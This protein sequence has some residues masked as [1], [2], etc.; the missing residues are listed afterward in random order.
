[1]RASYI[2]K[3]LA[4]LASLTILMSC[5]VWSGIGAA[6]QT[7]TCNFEGYT[8]VSNSD[9]DQTGGSKGQVVASGDAAHG[10]VMKLYYET[11]ATSGKAGF[12]FF[13]GTGT[14]FQYNQGTTPTYTKVTFDYQVQKLVGAAQLNVMCGSINWNG[15]AFNSN[16]ALGCD[17]HK[18]AVTLDPT[19][20]P[21]AWKTAS[22]VVQSHSGQNA[23]V[24]IY[25]QTLGNVANEAG[26]A[27]Y[28]DNVTV[29]TEYDPSQEPD[30]SVTSFPIDD[31]SKSNLIGNGSGKVVA[32]GAEY[33]HSGSATG[34]GMKMKMNQPYNA[35][36]C[37]NAARFWLENTDGYMMGTVGAKYEVTAW[38]KSMINTTDT[39]YWAIGSADRAANLDATV[40]NYQE[41]T[42]ASSAVSLTPGVW[43]KV[44]ATINS[45]VGAG[46]TEHYMTFA[47]GFNSGVNTYDNQYVYVD[48]IT[49][50]VLYKPTEVPPATAVVPEGTLVGV[51]TF[52]SG[53]ITDFT[54][55]KNV[56]RDPKIGSLYNY[57]QGGSKSLDVFLGVNTANNGNVSRPRFTVK[58]G[59][60]ANASNY[61]VTVGES[62]NLS[63]WVRST[64][65][66][67]KFGFYV[68]TMTAPET[69]LALGSSAQGNPYRTIQTATCNVGTA[70]G[71]QGGTEFQSIT[72]AANQWT[73]IIVNIPAVKAHGSDA[74]ATQYL[75]IHYTDTD[76]YNPNPSYT[77]CTLSLDEVSLYHVKEQWKVKFEVGDG[78]PVEDVIGDKNG[79]VVLPQPYRLGY[80]FTGWYK[81]VACTQPVTSPY[82]MTAKETTLYT[83]WTKSAPE[84]VDLTQ[85]FE[86]VADIADLTTNTTKPYVLADEGGNQSLKV[87][88]IAGYNGNF[89]R[90]LWAFQMKGQDTPMQVTPGVR[91]TVTFKVKPTRNITTGTFHISTVNDLSALTKNPGSSSVA[92]ADRTMQTLQKV[93]V[94]GIDHTKLNGTRQEAN[95]ISLKGGEWNTITVE[96]AAI[97]AHKNGAQY[98]VLALSDTNAFVDNGGAA[99]G[100]TEYDM[101]VDDVTLSTLV[102][103]HTTNVI[104]NTMGGDAMANGTG[105]IW[106]AITATATR[107]G[108][109]FDGWYTDATCSVP[110][111]EFPAKETV[112]LYAGW[113][114]EGAAVMDM[115]KAAAGQNGTVYAD[116]DLND[117]GVNAY[118]AGVTNMYKGGEANHAI[119]DDPDT[120]SG[121]GKVFSASYAAASDA[122][123]TPFGIRLVGTDTASKGFTVTKGQSYAVT[124]KYKV[125]AMPVPTEIRV[126]EGSINW[127]GPAFNSRIDHPGFTVTEADITKGWQEG[128][129]VFES[130]QGGQFGG[131]HLVLHA[132][133]YTKRNGTTVYFDDVK[134]ISYSFDDYK[135]GNHAANVKGEQNHTAG[136]SYAIKYDVGAVDRTQGDFG[137]V[138]YASKAGNKFFTTDSLHTF[139]GWVYSDKDTSVALG[140]ANMQDVT[141]GF[142]RVIAMSDV[143]NVKAGQWTRVQ[144]DFT[145]PSFT[146]EKNAYM[147]VLADATDTTATLYVDDVAIGT[148]VSDPTIM[149]TYE[150]LEAKTHPNASYFDGNLHG[151]NGNTV[152]S[153]KGYDGS[154]QSLKIEMAS[155]TELDASRAVLFFDRKDA[156]GKVSGSYIVTFYAMMEEDAEVTF[157]LGTSGT[158]DLSDRAEQATLYEAEA[159]S[160]VQL[161]AGKWRGVSVYVSDLQGKNPEMCL[162]PYLTLGAWFDGAASDNRKTVYIDNVSLREYIASEAAREDILCF[163][164]TDA[165]GFGKQLNLSA[166][167]SM[168]VVLE[169]NNTAGGNYALK[170]TTDSLG[171]IS[172]AGRP[173]FNLM[174]ANGQAIRV[175]KGKNYR[176]TFYVNIAES[177][178]KDELRYW[179]NLTD[180]QDSYTDATNQLRKDEQLVEVSSWKGT[181][182]AWKQI[183]VELTDLPRDGYLRLGISGTGNG[184]KTVFYL[185]DLRVFEFKEFT[186]TG[187]EKVLDFEKYNLE[188]SDFIRYSE[189]TVADDVNHT[190]GGANALRLKG[191]SNAGFQRNQFMLINPATKQP[192]EFVKGETYTLK[193]WLYCGEEYTDKFDLN[194]WVWGTDN[195]NEKFTASNHKND[196]NGTF[197]FDGGVLVRNEDQIWAPGEWNCYE[198]TFTAT[199]GKYMLVGMTDGSRY[200]GNYYYYVDDMQISVPERATV[201]FDANGGSFQDIKPELLNEKGQYVEAGFVGVLAVGPDI[202]PYLENKM[203]KG[204]ALDKEGTQMFDIDVD[205]VPAANVTLYAIWGEWTN[206]DGFGQ[207]VITKPGDSDVKY[208]TE[209]K[210]E[211]VWTGNAQIP[212]LESGDRPTL[213]E[214]DPVT[215]VPTTDKKDTASDGL[216][217]WL[218]IVIIVAAV[219]VVGGGAFLALFLLKNKKT[220]DEKEVNA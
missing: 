214:A 30:E 217:A 111:T 186:L 176:L 65:K 207:I 28:V 192:Y 41:T 171:A 112:T 96:I 23:A 38:V 24:H 162:A 116:V 198:I 152:V 147:A 166:N 195:V 142:D 150:S 167:G 155:D 184:E 133:D 94:N 181:V 35:S 156:I 124:F 42:F 100:F 115:E 144:F 76:C 46:G 154:S 25:L 114:S 219:V 208:K 73:Q 185:D 86:D 66:M 43:T 213:E 99:A 123:T 164:N 197:E 18:T 36:D 206:Q 165:F 215:Y 145:L 55:D 201:I 22:V 137:Y 60:A 29:I 157:G 56:S 118:Y 78:D 34:K 129:I 138:V 80:N 143:L 97:T 74:N 77:A 54:V 177:S 173:Q 72:L 63:F 121:R 110:I 85:D 13:A 68:S 188:D 141:T 183:S 50:K 91:A 57:T 27:V 12:R 70:S 161:T 3:A 92:N 200:D 87:H 39:F 15:E 159:T 51:Q 202:D 136:G 71:S 90:P 211:K 45:F 9:V 14:K 11:G 189:G 4:V 168:E 107:K 47:A 32:T 16:G 174:N 153:G 194:M 210:Y 203:F 151:L 5:M 109:V 128:M 220:N 2:K 127:Q 190:E 196:K 125:A 20:T 175:Q 59:D 148:N 53:A 21:G 67:S 120:A 170:V 103:G 122:G 140:V 31:L 117:D 191:N 8:I 187:N 178:L 104:Y 146:G 69:Q 216:P 180:K 139:S 204:W 49:I 169:Q 64:K 48:D 130:Q 98:L 106:T 108:Y 149:Q 88:M 79:T 158:I 126:L 209:I 105:I 1:M 83:K 40:Q 44:T 6:Q 132:S 199:N 62:Y 58:L 52:E 163:E 172:G 33:D 135:T 93:T 131:V 89:A 82:T 84:Q 61:A 17:Y 134:V 37:R 113:R 182:G 7:L 19:A 119:V 160:K 26:S 75:V 102:G 179:V 205:V 218:L 10:S 95:Q 101:Y 81:D 212:V 193:F